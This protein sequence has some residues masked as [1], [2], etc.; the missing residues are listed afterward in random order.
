MEGALGF[1]RPTHGLEN[2]SARRRVD[3][4]VGGGV[5]PIGGGVDPIVGGG[6]DPVVG[7]GVDP[8][9]GGQVDPVVGGGVYPVVGGGVD[10]VAEGRASREF[11]WVQNAG[12]H[13]EPRVK[14]RPSRVCEAAEARQNQ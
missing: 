14:C 11:F 3:P 4:V 8:V 12:Q 7:R 9:V 10:P 1:S 13:E 2:D 5:D 6:V